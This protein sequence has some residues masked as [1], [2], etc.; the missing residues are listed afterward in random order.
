MTTHPVRPDRAGLGRERWRPDKAGLR[1]TSC[2]RAATN[3]VDRAE[4]TTDW[5]VNSETGPRRRRFCRDCVPPGP[6]TDLTCIRC[7]D[8]PLLAGDLA[9]GHAGQPADAAAD[10]PDTTRDWLTGAG[11]QLSGPI[12]P[13]CPDCAHDLRGR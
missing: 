8:G 12:G 13:I 7:G 2:A 6:I 11:W 4:L 9:R 3:P 5:L 1:C 10:L